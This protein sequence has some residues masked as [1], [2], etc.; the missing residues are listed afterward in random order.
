MSGAAVSQAAGQSSRRNKRNDRLAEGHDRV[1]GTDM[2]LRTTS[3][4]GP[5]I[6][7][8]HDIYCRGGWNLVQP[9]MPQ[10]EALPRRIVGSAW[11]RFVIAE[12]RRWI[13]DAETMSFE[14]LNSRAFVPGADARPGARMC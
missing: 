14:A 3:D 6:G 12:P 9:G 11:R 10:T 2:V 13:S 8:C 7:R 5:L 4:R 1:A